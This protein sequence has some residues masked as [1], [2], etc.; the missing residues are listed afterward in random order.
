M[1]SN[2]LKKYCLRFLW[3]PY[4]YNSTYFL[5]RLI[6]FLEIFLFNSHKWKKNIAPW[7]ISYFDVRCAIIITGCR[8]GGV[9]RTACL[10]PRKMFG[11]HTDS[12]SPRYSNCNPKN[13]EPTT[14][15]RTI[16][17]DVREKLCM[18][19]AC[20]GIMTYECR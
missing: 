14:G 16:I 17:Q 9:V 19:W 8:T 3:I 18:R 12:S 20:V 4:N 5:M 15:Q 6:L 1:I 13:I 10:W 7:L 2:N 11:F